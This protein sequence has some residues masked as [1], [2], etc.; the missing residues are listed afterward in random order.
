VKDFPTLLKDLS[1]QGKLLSQETLR[2]QAKED[3]KS[4]CSQYIKYLHQMQGE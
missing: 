1:Q 4:G 2:N 3:K